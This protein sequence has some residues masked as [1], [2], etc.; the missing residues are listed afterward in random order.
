MESPNILTDK[1]N[2]G[3]LSVCEYRC[4]QKE[5]EGANKEISSAFGIFCHF[6][7][8]NDSKLDPHELKLLISQVGEHFEPADFQIVFGRLDLDKDG[9]I[10][11]DEFCKFLHSDAKPND[12]HD[13]RINFFKQKL[14]NQEYMKFITCNNKAVLKPVNRNNAMVSASLKVDIGTVKHRSLSWKITH[15]KGVNPVNAIKKQNNIKVTKAFAVLTVNLIDSVTDQQVA[16]LIKWL[17]TI[18]VD[19]Q[20]Q[21]VFAV[22]GKVGDQRIVTVTF[23]CAMTS[24][25]VVATLFSSLN[26]KHLNFDL[27]LDTMSSPPCLF[28][29][30]SAVISNGCV[31]LVKEPDF[32]PFIPLIK[33][34]ENANVDL[35]FASIQ[36]FIQSGKLETVLKLLGIPPH[37]ENYAL[38][39]QI[40]TSNDHSSIISTQL[41]KLISI[42]LNF[43]DSLSGG[44]SF[45]DIIKSFSELVL[46]NSDNALTL[47]FQY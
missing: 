9:A 8:S 23:I 20:I 21:Q 2:K 4:Q 25:V 42:I 46:C 32:Q 22:E 30:G 17:V 13:E 11:F 34:F 3:F 16:D 6:D 24:T 27:C 10:N 45:V 35:K 19:K 33:L 37:S 31:G 39:T 47:S 44:V 36:E 26:I 41:T 40:L 38:I 15:L 18:K 29:D 28:F 7:V 12:F 1:F 43:D 14:N 5:A